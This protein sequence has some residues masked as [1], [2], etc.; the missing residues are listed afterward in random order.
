MYEPNL[1]LKDLRRGVVPYLDNKLIAVGHDLPAVGPNR[2]AS[3]H[4][5]RANSSVDA[6]SQEGELDPVGERTA[7]SREAYRRTS[8]L[9]D[10]DRSVGIK[11]TAEESRKKA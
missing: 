10:R 6:V 11:E 8:S 4:L 5:P 1:V 2:N 9:P 7:R 3:C